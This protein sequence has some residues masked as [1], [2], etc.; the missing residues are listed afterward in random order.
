MTGNIPAN[1]LD[2]P[3]F[4]RF[5]NKMR[6]AYKIPSRDYKYPKVLIPKEFERVE[7]MV[8][9]AISTADYFSISSDG[10]DDTNS[11]NIINAV[12]HTPKPYLVKSIDATR[13]TK[14]GEYI[15]GII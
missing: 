2:N 10:W 3:F 1:F 11:N 9:E 4:R 15:A 8:S 13:E 7:T 14:T 5:L 12:A 6:P